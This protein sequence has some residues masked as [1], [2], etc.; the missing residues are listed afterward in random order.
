MLVS[1]FFKDRDISLFTTHFWSI[2]LSQK[3]DTQTRCWNTFLLFYHVQCILPFCQYRFRFLSSKR[4]SC[5]FPTLMRGAFE[6]SF[7]S[8]Q[9]AWRISFSTSVSWWCFFQFFLRIT[10]IFGLFNVLGSEKQFLWEFNF[11]NRSYALLLTRIV[12]QLYLDSY[13]CIPMCADQRS[14]LLS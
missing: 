14:S 13:G 6:L 10:F 11:Q 7:F 4:F 1:K 3:S 9:S 12:I 8:L 5:I 2:L